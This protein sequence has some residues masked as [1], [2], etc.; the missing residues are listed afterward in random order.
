MDLRNVEALKVQNGTVS[1][2]R[3]AGV[4]QVLSESPQTLNLD[5]QE[6]FDTDS[7]RWIFG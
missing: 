5:L 7:D 6:N 4:L 1:N 2:D 3:L